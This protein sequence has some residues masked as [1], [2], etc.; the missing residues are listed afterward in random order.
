MDDGIGHR[1]NITHSN[2]DAQQ[3]VCVCVYSVMTENEFDFKLYFLCNNNLS[4]RL[5]LKLF[6]LHDDDD[7]RAELFW[8]GSWGF[9]TN[10]RREIV[11]GFVP[12][13]RFMREIRPCYISLCKY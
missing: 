12:N 2:I 9:L 10:S 4:I 7:E 3:S 8:Q 5:D 6:Q 1:T 13:G 11:K